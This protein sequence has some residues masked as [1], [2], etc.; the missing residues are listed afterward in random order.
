MVLTSW[1]MKS[2]SVRG[3]ASAEAKAEMRGKRSGAA[4]VSLT[5]LGWTLR[6]GAKEIEN[7]SSFT[8]NFCPVSLHEPRLV[9]A[10]VMP[11]PCETIHFKTRRREEKGTTLA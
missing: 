8:S 3:G 4:E 5:L 2:P 1:P 11:Q 6:P 7:C 10:A 9:F